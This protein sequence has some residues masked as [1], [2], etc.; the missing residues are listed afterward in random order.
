M[1][2]KNIIL[3]GAGGNLGVSLLKTLQSAN[4]FNITILSRESSK[5]TFPSTVKTIKIAD[6]YPANEL[7]A[8][9]KNQD[10]VLS[11]VGGLGTGDQ[12]K[13]IDAAVK[14]GVK[15][16]FPSEFGSKLSKK[17]AE[18]FPGF[19]GKLQVVEYLKAQESKGL[20]WTAIVNG[21]FFDWYVVSPLWFPISHLQIQI[22]DFHPKS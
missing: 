9:F 21:P 5:S 22:L 17:A 4:A 15:R 18:I 19:E 6:D 13:F 8:A 10:A 12:P 14:A 1:S 11:L 2:Y 16:F 3:I 7:E 20:S